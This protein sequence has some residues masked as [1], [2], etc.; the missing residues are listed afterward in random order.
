MLAIYQD[1]VMKGF[2]PDWVCRDDV[3]FANAFRGHY[4]QRLQL[5]PL[6][7]NIAALGFSYANTISQRTLL[8]LV[9]VD[10]RPVMVFVDRIASDDRRS[11]PAE[12]NLHLHR[13]IIG[14]LVVYELSPF[15]EP[16]VLSYFFDP[17]DPRRGITP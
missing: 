13:A 9:R 8:V 4:G 17:D 7:G 1:D 2:E 15:E 6:P 10:E 14:E 16:H 12:S 3:E 5:H 11:W